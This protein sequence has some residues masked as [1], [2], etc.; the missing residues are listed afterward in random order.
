MPGGCCRC[1]LGGAS[2]PVSPLPTGMLKRWSEA[3]VRLRT[4]KRFQLLVA[5]ITIFA[6]FADILGTAII[7][8]GLASVCTFAEGGPGHFLEQ[9][10]AAGLLSQEVYEAQTQQYISPHA[11]KG[12]PG[13]WSGAPP[14]PYSL[15]MNLVMSLGFLGSAL[16]SLFF[17][18]LC[19]KMGC[20]IP[21][22]ICL[23]MGILGYVIIYASAIWVKSY[24]LFMLG[25]VWNNFFGNCMQIA[26]T[27]FGQLFDGAERDNYNAMVLG[28]GLI[29]GTVGAFIVMPFSNNPSN[30]ANYFESIWLAAGITGIALLAV[31][32]VLVPPDEKRRE[33]S[34]EEEADPALHA[35]P[36]LAYRILLLTVV[37]SALDSA[38]D[39]GTRMARGTI[40]T[41]LFPDW[42]T[43]ERQ[44]YLLMG[45]LIMVIFSLLILQVLQRC[46]NLAAVAVIGCVFTLATQ[47]VLILELDVWGFLAVWYAGKL[48]GF[49][50]TLASG[51]IITEIAPKAQL[52][53]WSGINEACSN[54][55][56]A[57]APLVFAT[58]YDEVGNIRG[59][60]MLVC[61]SVISLFAL[62]AYA[63]LVSMMPKRSKEEPLELKEMSYYEGLSDKEF[64]LLPME[65]VEE[66]SSKMIEAG[67]APRVVHWG[68]YSAERTMLP[69]FQARAVKDFEYYSRECV[70][71]LSNRE[72]LAKEQKEMATFIATTGQVD[73]ERAQKEMG[74]WLADYLDDAGYISWETQSSIYKAMIMTAFPPIDPLD[75]VKPEFHNMWAGPLEAP[76]DKCPQTADSSFPPFQARHAAFWPQMTSDFLVS[77]SATVPK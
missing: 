68:S 5:G 51:L 15:S 3:Q 38:G 45:L 56:M 1:G 77:Q 39:E 35:T 11:F 34:S 61:T 75:G 44:N 12:E 62:L 43:A 47:L 31:T 7:M 66:V 71:M 20:K 64:S 46:M 57:I 9:Q 8:P 10:L 40:L 26:S 76:W 2:S 49:L 17:G 52:G 36:R 4:S 63:P 29:G 18:W 42:Q 30:G 55:S 65:I 16:G 73:R 32:L 54:I 28:M 14:V 50:S 23:G 74:A 21:M 60:E 27:Y 33:V 19:D 22:Q 25:N 72:L 37:A 70:R 58:V 48:F 41:R 59:Q 6:V 53:R 24:Y 67:K 13:S 69:E